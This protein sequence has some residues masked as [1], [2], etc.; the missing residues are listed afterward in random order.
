MTWYITDQ[1]PDDTGRRYRLFFSNEKVTDR[2]LDML[3]DEGVT[4]VNLCGRATS[5]RSPDRLAFLGDLSGVVYHELWDIGSAVLPSSSFEHLEVLKLAGRSA[6]KVDPADLPRLRFFVGRAEN[7][8]PGRFGET[9]RWL[10]LDRWQDREVSALPFGQGIEYLRV[11]CEGQEVSFHGLDAPALEILEL[12][13][14]EVES[15][16]GLEGAPHLRTLSLQPPGD[17]PSSLREIDMR[18][19]AVHQDLQWLRIGRQGRMTHLEA[20]A[21]VRTLRQVHGY[22]SFFPPSHLDQPWA[23]PLRDSRLVARLVREG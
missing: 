20:L 3:R 23:D 19:L 5:G 12:H 14:V 1:E 22:R 21:G 16:A 15:L 18:P 10:A 13:D 11:G 9:M 17:G 8:H 6:A 7:L 2:H 4:A